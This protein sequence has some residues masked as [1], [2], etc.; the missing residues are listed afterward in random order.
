MRRILFLILCCSPVC[1]FSQFYGTIGPQAWSTDENLKVGITASAGHIIS[2]GFTLGAGIGM[3]FFDEGNP[4][5]P[6][7]AEIGYYQPNKKVSPYFNIRAGYGLYEGSGKII[8]KALKLKGGFFSDIRAGAGLRISK[9]IGIVPFI[10]AS[11]FT[12]QWKQ[13]HQKQNFSSVFFS[14][15]LIVTSH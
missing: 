4:Y 3:I 10:S 14:F 12:F 6:L 7:F 9:K 1:L 8:D 5:I 13:F 11:P 15:G 2:E